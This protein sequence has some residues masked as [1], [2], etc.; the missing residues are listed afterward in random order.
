MSEVENLKEDITGFERWR[1][2]A[3]DFLF[4]DTPP[5]KANFNFGYLRTEVLQAGFDFGHSAEKVQFLKT[6]FSVPAKFVELARRVSTYRD[7]HKWDLLYRVLWRLTRGELSMLDVAD[8]D[9]HQLELMSKAIK[10]DIHKTHAFV[11]FKRVEGSGGAELYVAWYEPTHLTLPLSAPFFERRFGDQAW[12]IFTPDLSAH[13][14]KRELRYSRGIS[15]SEFQHHDSF[16][17]MW[18]SYYKSIFN[19]ARLKLKA[20]QAEMPK[21]AW[22]NL[23]EAELIQ[24]LIRNAP[25]RL[26]EMA[27]KQNTRAQTPEGIEKKDWANLKEAAKSCVGCPLYK[28]ATQ[29]VFGE[30]SLDSKILVVGE[31]PGDQEDLSG[32]P[33]VGPAGDVFNR[34][35]SEAQVDRKSLYITNAVKHFKWKPQGKRRLHQKPN[36][37]EMH[38]CRSWLDREVRIVKPKVILALGATAATSILGRAVKMSTERG[39]VFESHEFNCQVVVSWHPSAILRAMDDTDARTKAADLSSDLALANSLI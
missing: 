30:G 5:A 24:D 4:R 20:M 15:K 25:A 19:P 8:P 37:A 36:G 26:Q 1:D 18:K 11:R 9:L 28:N 6:R 13:W 21:K 12:S 38:A 27:L 39:T 22:A 33:F 16:D 10:R 32:K 23:P 7:D 14:D 31:Q 2:R 35:L 17:E 29:T 34:A 3:R